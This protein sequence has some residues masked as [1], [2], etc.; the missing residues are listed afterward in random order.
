MPLFYC[1]FPFPL[2]LI[3]SLSLL[4]LSLSLIPHI[5]SLT[6]APL[7]TFHLVFPNEQIGKTILLLGNTSELGWK[8][9]HGVK[10]EH[11][12]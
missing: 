9:E 4:P 1:L 3:F 6:F 11:V 12:S 5:F 7:Q 10:L 2:S 8:P